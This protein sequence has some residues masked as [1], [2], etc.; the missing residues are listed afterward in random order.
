[1]V[2]CLGRGANLHMAQ[3]MPLHSL[4]LALSFL[5]PAHPGS[6]GQR[7]IKWVLLLLLYEP[8]RLGFLNMWCICRK[9]TEHSL[10]QACDPCRD[11]AYHRL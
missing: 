3:L 10:C 4:S 6:P 8:G 2:I 5:V 9:K 1:M 11:Q 7:A